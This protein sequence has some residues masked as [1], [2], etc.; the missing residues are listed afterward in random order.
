MLASSPR[1]VGGVEVGGDA[2]EVRESSSFPACAATMEWRDA[3]DEGEVCRSA[4]LSAC[5]V[6]RVE[7]VDGQARE[8]LRGEVWVERPIASIQAR[9]RTLPKYGR[10]KQAATLQVVWAVCLD[11]AP[12]IGRVS[13]LQPYLVCNTVVVE[14]L[15]DRCGKVNNRANDHPNQPIKCYTRHDRPRIPFL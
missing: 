3:I 4:M 8:V 11:N 6:C 14:Q 15:G 12:R 13:F 2:V 7:V 1:L 9:P 10:Y 5:D